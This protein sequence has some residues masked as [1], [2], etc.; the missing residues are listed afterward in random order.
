MKLISL[1]QGKFAKVDD[2]DYEW[3]VQWNWCAIRQQGIYKDTWYA[4][5][6]G[7][8]GYMHRVVARRAGILIPLKIIDHW[9]HDGLNNQRNNLR[10]CSRSQNQQNSR[11]KQSLCSSR[12]KG[13]SWINAYSAWKASI[14]VEGKGT[15]LGYFD[16]EVEAARV[17]DQAAIQYHGIFAVLNFPRIEEVLIV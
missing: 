14:T 17:Y 16:N 5:S 6:K 11:K 13:V 10:P 3:L 15:S 2:I 4:G 12:Y 9:D 1:T 7:G 8:G